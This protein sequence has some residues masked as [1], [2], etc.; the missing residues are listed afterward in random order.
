MHRRLREASMQTPHLHLFVVLAYRTAGRTAAI[1]ELTW[2]RVDLDRRL[3]RLDRG[4]GRQ[5]GRAT[6]PISDDLVPLLADASRG[7]L[8][9]HVIDFGGRPIASVKRA[10]AAAVQRAG[11]DDVSPHVVRHSAAV[12]MAEAGVPIEEIADYLGHSDIRITKRVYARF[13]PGHLRRAA[14]AAE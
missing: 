7:A 1:L 13:S 5:K 10:F 4:G 6:V 12:H 3:I 8:T 11:L 2:G 9:D 14:E